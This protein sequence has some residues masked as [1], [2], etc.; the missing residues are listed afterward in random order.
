MQTDITKNKVGFVILISGNLRLGRS[1]EHFQ[2]S[3]QQIV[4]KQ[5]LISDILRWSFPEGTHWW[6]DN[7][8]AYF[9]DHLRLLSSYWKLPRLRRYTKCNK[10]SFYGSI[11]V[12]IVSVY[13]CT[14]ICYSITER[15]IHLTTCKPG[16]NCAGGSESRTR[17]LILKP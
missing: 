8:T 6:T 1:I 15:L 7:T 10:C 4:N 16:L 2:T 9:S 13:V 12:L 3:R 5:W 17:I 14:R 11:L